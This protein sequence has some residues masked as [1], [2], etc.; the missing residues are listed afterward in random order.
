MSPMKLRW[1]R[2]GVDYNWMQFPSI[3]CKFIMRM[4]YASDL[5]KQFLLISTV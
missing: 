3:T 4:Q 5:V 1:A 2:D